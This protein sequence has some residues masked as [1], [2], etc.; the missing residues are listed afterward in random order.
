MKEKQ[1]NK[2]WFSNEQY[3]NSDIIRS[4]QSEPNHNVDIALIYSGRKRGKSFDISAKA[5]RDAYLSNGERTFG[6]IRRYDKELANYKVEQYFADKIQFI[7]DL[8][9]NKCD[10]VICDRGSI[11]LGIM[12]EDEKGKLKREKVIQ[13]GNT[14]ALNM[15]TQYKSLQ[16]PNIYTLIFEEVFTIDGYLT[17]EPAKLLSIISTVQRDKQGFTTFMIS[18]TVS[19]INPYTQGFSLKGVLKQKSGTV[20]EYKLYKGT[21]DSRGMEEYFYICVEYLKDLENEMTSKDKNKKNKERLLSSISSNKWEEAYIFPTISSKVMKEFDT[22]YTCVFE[23]NEFKYMCE[24]K[25]VPINLQFAYEYFIDT[26]QE[27]EYN[28]QMMEVCFI[29]RK[30][31]KITDN[32]RLFTT[33]PIVTPLTTRGY[34]ILND[35]DETVDKLIDIGHCF[36]ADNLTANEFKQSFDELKNYSI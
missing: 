4:M 2:K 32:T 14:F 5:I 29:Q 36:F 24:L 31:T 23:Y 26:E 20:D 30:T 16:Y 15:S 22:I 35:M 13:I 27:I 19:K 17:E 3:Y 1:L 12:M 34:F 21:T 28:S 8:T 18:N 25:R 11:Y 9:D 6:Y 33:N 10:C 7:K